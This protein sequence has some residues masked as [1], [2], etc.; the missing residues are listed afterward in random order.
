MSVKGMDGGYYKGYAKER[1]NLYM[2]TTKPK[3]EIGRDD[4]GS[5]P[6]PVIRAEI[7]PRW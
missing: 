7:A 2:R 5:G 4:N 3:Q 6:S 1:G